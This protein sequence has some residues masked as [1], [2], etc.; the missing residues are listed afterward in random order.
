MYE[1]APDFP[2]FGRFFKIIQDNKVSVFYT[3]PTAIRMFMKAG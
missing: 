3:A 2:D 1:G